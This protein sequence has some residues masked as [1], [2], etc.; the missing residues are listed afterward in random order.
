MANEKL[1]HVA[2]GVITNKRGEVLV[3][4]RH[5][6]AHQ[7]GLWEF[8]GGKV[9][10]GESV[11]TALCR[12]FREELGITPTV[13]FPFKKILHQYSDKAVLLD[14]WL[15]RNYEGNPRGCE[16]QEIAWQALDSLSYEDFPVANKPIINA[17]HLPKRIP[18]TPE[19]ESFSAFKTLLAHWMKEGC[20]LGYFQQ[21]DLPADIYRQWLSSAL[22]Y[23]V[24]KNLGLIADYGKFESSLAS[25][26]PQGIHVDSSV[27]MELRQRP[28][29]PDCYFSAT[30]H[31]DKELQKA[32]A[33]NADFV[34]LAPASVVDETSN[35]SEAMW[36]T[37]T[38]LV[39]GVSLPVYALNGKSPDSSEEAVSHGAFGIAGIDAK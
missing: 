7:G 25:T 19:L 34:F 14:V 21:N 3:S 29:A 28:A 38:R 12:E 33:L 11:A 31:N 1:V 15:I 39:E 30:C 9:D 20:Q 10:A 6:D 22:D 35:C 37:F 8:P 13:F 36:N 32:E 16:G 24:D 4:L 2:V 26:T 5:P 27:L 23:C 18:I 17:L